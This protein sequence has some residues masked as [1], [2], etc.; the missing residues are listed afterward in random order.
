MFKLINIELKKVFKHK[1]IYIIFFIIFLFCMLNNVLYKIDYDS[2]GNYKYESKTDLT[3]YISKLEKRNNEYD[4]SKE[5][6]KYLYITNRSK[7]EVAK[8]QKK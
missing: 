2:E 7:I 6:D 1:S 4:L 5:S 8:I 3:K